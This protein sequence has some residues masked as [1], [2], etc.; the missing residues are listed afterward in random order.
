VGE[1]GRCGQRSYPPTVSRPL[2]RGSVATPEVTP[3]DQFRSACAVAHIEKLC[4]PFRLG[5]TTG[6]SADRTTEL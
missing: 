6:A 3:P 5:R 2:P 4:P 1:F